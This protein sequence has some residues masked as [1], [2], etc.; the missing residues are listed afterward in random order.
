MARSY[1]VQIGTHRGWADTQAGVHFIEESGDAQPED[2]V[3]D[4][5]ISRSSRCEVR[6]SLE[7]RE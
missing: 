4:V 1:A 7:G 3:A 5:L 2:S 6:K